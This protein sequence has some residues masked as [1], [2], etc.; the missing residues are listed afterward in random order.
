VQST[1]TAKRGAYRH[2]AVVVISDSEE[3]GALNVVEWWG[4][5]LSEVKLTPFF[6][7]VAHT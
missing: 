2:V 4:F 6:L 3:S 5:G 7:E 1:P